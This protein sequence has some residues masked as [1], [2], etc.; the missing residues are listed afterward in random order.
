MNRWLTIVLAALTLC[1]CNVERIVKK[2]DQKRAIGEYY[3]AGN[4]Y[5]RAYM[6]TPVKEKAKRSA[7]ALAAA[8]CY[9]R[10]AFASRAVGCYGNAM[11]YKVS[12]STALFYLAEMQKQSG[13]YKRAIE[14]YDAYLALVPDDTLALNGRLGALHAQIWKDHPTNYT[15]K[16]E[17][18]LNGRRSDYCPMLL[19]DDA[20]Q[21]Y[22]TTT[23]PQVEGDDISGI[24]GMKPGDIFFCRKDDKGKWTAMEAAGGELNSEE[25]EGACCFTP[26]G[27]T[28]YFTRC[29]S[30]PSYPRYA[31]IYSSQRSDAAWGA[32]K[33]V[34]ISRDTLSSFAHPAVSPDGKWL[35]FTSD[36]PGGMGGL[37]IWRCNIEGKEVGPAENLGPEIN[38]PGDEC[39][40][41]WRPNGEFYFSS[42]GHVGMGGL[43]IFVCDP[44]APGTRPVNLGWPMNGP[45]DDFGMTWEGVHNRGYFCS[46]RGD[47]RGWDHLL[48]FSKPEILQTVKGWVY[49]KDGY[50][51][52]E[53]LVYLV[54]NDGTN[55]KL[56]VKGD[57]SFTQVINPNVKYVMLGTCHGYLNHKEELC[58]DTVSETTEYVLQFPLSSI[59]SPVLV[60]N[61]FYEFDRAD[62]TPDSRPALDSLITLLNENPNVT[63]E[64]ASHT[65]FRGS[66]AYNMRLSQRRAESVVRYLIDGG[67]A[68]DR[69]SPVGYG[70]SRPKVVTRKVHEQYDWLAIG[71]TLTEA[72]ITAIDDNERVEACHA[73]N[74]RTEFRVLRTTYGLFDEEKRKQ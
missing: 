62:I 6:R 68:S 23:R 48:S 53:A 36:M 44:K 47:A 39:F 32:A 4:L 70:E 13:E 7:R 55:L 65:D 9:R 18:A 66:D 49:E 10:I 16:K 25:D 29:G 74:R 41:A 59:S 17:N 3:E 72:F 24:T 1:A 26:D 73:L 57:G 43:D 71:D 21:L 67:I 45:G 22:V 38:T 20:D 27:K 64:L 37:D 60:R 52:P 30:D 15:V 56:S 54:G 11:R 12:D 63:I 2:A 40:P 19:G 33:V 46:N 42:N 31:K 51:L 28:M 5:R 35:Y 50:E 61:V 34:E 69:L 14:N 58:V 8:D